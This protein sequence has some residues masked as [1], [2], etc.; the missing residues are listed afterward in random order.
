MCEGKDQTVRWGMEFLLAH[1]KQRNDAEGG[2]GAVILCGQVHPALPQAFALQ[3][4]LSC[5]ALSTLSNMDFGKL[6]NLNHTKIPG[7]SV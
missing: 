6:M 1:R 5:R 2:D 4:A 3:L 7:I